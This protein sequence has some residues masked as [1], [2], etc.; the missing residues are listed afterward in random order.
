MTETFRNGGNFA[1]AGSSGSSRGSLSRSPLSISQG[2][3]KLSGSAGYSSLKPY[4]FTGG[5]FGGH[6]KYGVGYR[7][8]SNYNSSFPSSQAPMYGSNSKK[9]Y[10]KI[11]KHITQGI[12]SPIIGNK[13]DNVNRNKAYKIKRPKYPYGYDAR[14]K[15]LTGYYGYSGY[16]YGYPLNGLSQNYFNFIYDYDDLIHSDDDTDFNDITIQNQI[17]TQ[18]FE[19][20][21][22]E[23]KNNSNYDDK[24]EGF[25]SYHTICNKNTILIILAVILIIYI[26]L[27]IPISETE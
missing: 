26:L 18:N 11:N 17:A 20:E 21:E 23:K 9:S 19:K 8:K 16:G 14:D 1:G 2:G 6:G 15:N 10:G 13:Y 4:T 3:G 7:G 5:S 12:P 24:K 25:K 22:A 27:R